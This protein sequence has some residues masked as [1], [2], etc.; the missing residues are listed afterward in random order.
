LQ[1][2]RAELVLV[3]AALLPALELVSEL[4]GPLVDELAIEFC[5]LV[6]RAVCLESAVRPAPQQEAEILKAGLMETNYFLV[7]ALCG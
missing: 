2:Q 7:R 1:A 3:Q 4:G 6:H 5:V